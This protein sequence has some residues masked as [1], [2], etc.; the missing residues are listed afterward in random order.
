VLYFVLSTL[1]SRTSTDLWSAEAQEETS[2]LAAPL[3][4]AIEQYRLDYEKPPTTLDD[5]IPEYITEIPSPTI[6]CGKW[7][8][9]P[10]RRSYELIVESSNPD[11]P[12]LI[13]MYIFGP[14]GFDDRSFVY[15][16]GLEKWGMADL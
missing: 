14:F 13:L 5:L 8:Y 2:L 9:Q 12:P 4:A 1:G 15:Y 16:P 7:S 6:G 3:V 11:P 10:T